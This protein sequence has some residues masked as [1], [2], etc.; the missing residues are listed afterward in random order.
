MDQILLS[1]DGMA[2]EL[3]AQRLESIFRKLAGVE[4][5]AVNFKS[6]KGSILYYPEILRKEDLL[7]AAL[8]ACFKAAIITRGK[9]R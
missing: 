2:C 6:K 1:I 8:K 3:C 7:E 4:E 5:A 9:E